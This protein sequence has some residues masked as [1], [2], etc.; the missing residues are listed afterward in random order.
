M[1]LA[2]GRPHH[3]DGEWLGRL[4]RA[5]R[6]WEHAQRP[7]LPPVGSPSGQA[8][9]R[10]R[11]GGG[12]GARRLREVLLLQDGLQTEEWALQHEL[13]LWT[14]R[15]PATALPL[16]RVLASTLRN[17][18]RRVRVRLR[19]D[20]IVHRGIVGEGVRSDAILLGSHGGGHGLAVV[21]WRRRGRGRPQAMGR[22][23]VPCSV[24]GRR[25]R[26]VAPAADDSFSLAW[27]APDVERLAGS[28]QNHLH[29][30]SDHLV[31]T[32]FRV[33]WWGPPLRGHRW[34]D[35]LDLHNRGGR[36]P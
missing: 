24:V 33:V 11:P 29:R 25:V 31:R 10:P 27:R 20:W 19:W 15:L 2:Q 28:S 12:A 30:R 13:E 22:C 9:G 17:D 1:T 18:A 26:A 5:P 16:P 14:P 3:F 4:E 32:L 6:L 34:A 21:C 35:R 23:C 36:E 8:E 7:Q